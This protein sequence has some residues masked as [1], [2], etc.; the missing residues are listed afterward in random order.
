[1]MIYIIDY[2]IKEKL[3]YDIHS[4]IILSYRHI[5]KFFV[6]QQKN[7]DVNLN[8]QIFYQDFVIDK[9]ISIAVSDDSANIGCIKYL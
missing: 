9:T 1:M 7:L 2:E 5:M 3:D 4:Y 6:F 8:I